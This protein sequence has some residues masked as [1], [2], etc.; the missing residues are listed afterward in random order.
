ML[1]L[2]GGVQR[3][4]TGE[5]AHPHPS[6]LC[7]FLPQFLQAGMGGG[8]LTPFYHLPRARSDGLVG[9]ITASHNAITSLR[10]SLT[11]TVNCK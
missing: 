10:Y 7:G 2:V 3:V 6:I 11:E 4:V 1:F 8:V 5:P 9:E